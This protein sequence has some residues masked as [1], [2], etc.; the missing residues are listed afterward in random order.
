MVLGMGTE[1]RAVVARRKQ[2]IEQRLV[3]D[4]QAVIGH[5]DLDRGM[6]LLDQRRQIRLQ[7]LFGRVG[8]DHVKGVV[9]DGAFSRER[10]IVLEHLWQ[11]HADVLGRERDHRGGAAEGRR[12]G[13]ALE[14]IGVHDARGRELLDMR[15]AVDA[16]RQD[17]LAAR[18]D[19]APRPLA[20]RGRW[21]RSSRRKWRHRPRTRRLR[22]RRVRRG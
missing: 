5:E 19:L 18:V 12:D 4:F 7:R 3:V 13:G 14:R 21:P 6:A 8:D 20:G 2:N 16:A 1:Q 15:M 10:M 9:D 17:Q 11:F 22:S